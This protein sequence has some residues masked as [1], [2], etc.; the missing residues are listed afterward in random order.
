MTP[1]PRLD[2][3]HYA[4]AVIGGGQA[5]LSVSHCLGERGVDHVVIEAHRVGHEWRERRW[6]SFCLVTPNWQC[7]L[8][9]HPYTGSDPDGFM[10]RDDIVRY[11][12][13]YVAAF[14]PPLVE[15][16][17]V[18]RLRRSVR[19]V[20]EVTTTAGE[21][22]ADQVVVATGP[23]HTP[24]LPRMAERLPAAIE[25]FHSSG[26]R[27]PD[28]LPDGAVLVV[29][30]GQ[31]GCQIAEDL[32]LAGRQVH[33]AVGGAPRVAR[34]YRG[35]DCVAWLD[36]MGHYTKN[37]DGF[38]DADAVRLRVNHYVTGRDGGRDI[39]LRA[40]ARD[41]MRLYGR[42][43]EVEGPVLEFADDLKTNLDH[44]DAVAESIKDAIDAHIEAAG[45]PAPTEARY[46]PVWQPDDQPGTLDLTEAGVTSVVWATGFARDHRWIEIP[47]F[48]GRGYPMHRRGVGS[49][50]GLYFLGLPWQYTWG[51]G[52]FEAVGRDAEFLAD[53]ID[54]S[55]RLAD[56]CGTLTGA[57]SALASALPIG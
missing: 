25:Q 45:I 12:E 13:E 55:R 41:G 18:T 20:F 57:P 6:D 15:G 11:L 47:A 2:G 9:G 7:R 14:G 54:A 38:D 46:R 27:N 5:G 23:Y 50:P 35:R 32:H 33:L 40:F 3:G 26:Y 19:G 34:F 31:S 30:T 21:F 16:V 10:V 29:G 22:T 44:A 24:K 39:D 42:L 52:R 51:S 53:H 4:A 48:D 36:D 17:S 28:R 37:I 43:T 1:V 8:P 49:V 56:V